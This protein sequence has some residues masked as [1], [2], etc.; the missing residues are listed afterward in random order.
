MAKKKTCESCGETKSLKLFKPWKTQLYGVTRRC[1]VCLASDAKKKAK[2]AEKPVEQAVDMVNSPPHYQN[3]GVECIDAMIQVFGEDAVRT[4][5]RCNAFK[6]IWRAPYKGKL[7]EDLS[8]AQWYLRF[9]EGDDPRED[10][11]GS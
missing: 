3:N 10:T 9:S 11:H 6:Y 4:Y 5:A 2:A 1:K 8:K 7:E